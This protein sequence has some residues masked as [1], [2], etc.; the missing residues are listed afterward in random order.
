MKR[1]T[2]FSDTAL[3]RL[4]K[5]S[6]QRHVYMAIAWNLVRM[7]DR[8]SR[9]GLASAIR[10]LIYEKADPIFQFTEKPCGSD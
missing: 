5:P 3:H 1:H 7:I 9:V 4:C 2:R 6:R 8:T 10:V